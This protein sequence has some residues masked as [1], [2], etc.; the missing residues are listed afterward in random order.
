MPEDVFEGLRSLLDLRNS[1]ARQTKAI[2][3]LKRYAGL[4]SGY[5]PIT[6]LAEARLSERFENQH[7]I[8]AYIEEV[9]QGLNNTEQFITGIADLFKTAKL[10]GR[11][12]AQEKL[13]REHDIVTLRLVRLASVSHPKPNRRPC[14][15][16]ISFLRVSLVIRASAENSFYLSVIPIRRAALCRMISPMKLS[17][18][19]SPLM[20]RV[21]GTTSSSLP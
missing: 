14:R 9:N 4:E 10:T 3:R 13:V 12:E 2:T 20:K 11:E 21:P 1:S 15:H 16:R 17:R 19:L 8:G 18:G 7:L 5:E 6:Q